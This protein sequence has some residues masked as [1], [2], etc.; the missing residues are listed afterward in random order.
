MEDSAGSKI[1]LITGSS[2]GIGAATA[3]RLAADG[4]HVV[5]G[6]R[7]VDR[8]AA[9][10]DELRAAGGTASTMSWTLRAETACSPS[11][12]APTNGTAASTYW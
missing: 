6:A 1:V 10:V 7:R 9:L 4:H 2:S 3:R 12:G 5:L 8:L 11:S